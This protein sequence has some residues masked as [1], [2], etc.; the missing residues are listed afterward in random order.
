MTMLDTIREAQTR[1]IE[2]MKSTQEQIVAFNERVADTMLG[3]MPEMQS[4]FA[5]YLPSP[6]EL[7]DAYFSF[8][9]DLYES[10]KDFAT[11]IATVWDQSE[12][13]TKK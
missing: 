8:M 3:S 2:Q 4:P 1:S 13:A 5:D 11:R 12:T 10:N 7:V 6:V 9:G